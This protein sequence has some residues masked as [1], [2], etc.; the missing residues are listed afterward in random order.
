MSLGVYRV[1]ATHLV[2]GYISYTCIGD[3]TY[4]IKMRVYRD[5]SRAS[6]ANFDTTATIYVTDEFFVGIDTLRV[7]RSPTR[8]VLVDTSSCIVIPPGVCVEYADYVDT[9]VLPPRVGGYN[10]YY[11]RCCRNALI[12]NINKPLSKAYTYNTHIPSMDTSGN[13]SA[14]LPG[15]PPIFICHN[16]PLDLD[17]GV[18]EPDGDS[19]HYELCSILGDTGV[20]SDFLDTINFLS[21][22]SATFPMASSPAFSIDAQTG[23]LSGVPTQIG[24]YVVGMC[25]S[26]FRNGELLSTVRLDYQF[27][28]TSCVNIRA[29]ILTQAEDSSL[30]CYGLNMKFFPQ[31]TN[32]SSFLWDFGDTT[33][34]GDTSTQ[35]SPRYRYSAPGTYEVTLIA[36]PGKC[37]DTTTATFEVKE[38]I[39]PKISNTGTYCFSDQPLNLS[40]Q[41]QFPPGA[42]F[43]WDFGAG[44]NVTS[45]KSLI[46]PQVSWDSGGTYYVDFSVY[47]GK[48]VET[49]TDTVIIRNEIIPDMI[50][51]DEDSSL[52]CEGLQ[53]QFFS[54]TQNA[55]SVTWNFGDPN[56]VADFSRDNNP[57]Y[58]YPAPG[59]YTVTLTAYQ[60]NDCSKSMSWPI[61]VQE[62]LNA[63]ID[64]SGRFCFESQ[65]IMLQANGSYPADTEFRWNFGPEARQPARTGQ[66]TDVQYT[67]PGKYPVRLVSSRGYC[68]DTL[69]DTIQVT[70][71]T[72]VVDAGDTQYVDR[73]RFVRL[74]SSPGYQI[75][76]FADQPVKIA[77]PFSS[78]TSAQLSPQTDS[79]K[80]Y[81]KLTD[82]N[83]CEGIDSVYVYVEEDADPLPNFITPNADGMNDYLDLGSAMLHGDCRFTILNRWGSEVYHGD[84]GVTQWEGVND[85]GEPLSDATYYYLIYCHPR[86]VAKGAVTIVRGNRR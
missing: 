63:E 20:Q 67:S 12:V 85:S 43:E 56:S 25:V 52:T 8:P 3:S 58:L 75:Y 5:C 65:D 51:P 42:S 76:W 77:S 50:T 54:E 33:V 35:R 14:Q 28:V 31:N 66:I 39:K 27:N 60:G 72:V 86:V 79:I 7:P 80:F 32:A 41:G 70:A 81:V 17:L 2:G 36:D 47:Y 22:Y 62:R 18:F 78:A 24:H 59:V 44:A 83:G 53:V 84:D 13:S 15:V 10:V 9:V 64:I 1:S 11:A 37:S 6:N 34:T 71:F 38:L 69:F 4:E 49:R 29:D 48:C 23:V 46:P 68:T 21:P 16:E 74:Q 30:Y 55:T 82:V 61:E 73:N 26:E 57:S 19:L 40:A 45:S